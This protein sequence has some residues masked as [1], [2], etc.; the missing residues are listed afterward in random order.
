MIKKKH[1]MRHIVYILAAMPLL[2]G[3][4]GDFLEE[5]SQSEVIP[6]TT[7]DYS[8]LLIGNGYPDQYYPSFSF[9]AMMDD[10]C[11]GQVNA[12]A[13]VY[14]N[15]R[16]YLGIQNIFAEESQAVTPMPYYTWQPYEEDLD[17]YGS[18]INTVAST[19][20]YGQYYKKIMGCNAVLDGI[21]DAIGTQE[22]R[23][24]VKAEAL[25]VRALL[26]FQLV[27][28]FGEPYNYNPDAPGV[29][30]KLNANLSKD[31]I[32]RSSV[33]E[34]YNQIVADLTEAVALMDPLEIHTSNYRINQPALH[35]LLSR[36][37][38]FMERYQDCIDECD[39]AL[40]MG[41]R[42]AN[43]TVELNSTYSSS[44]SNPFT[45][46]NPE[47]LWNFGPSTKCGYS[48]CYKDGACTA[49]LNLWAQYV[50]SGMT[51][52]D[53]D[54]D[55][56]WD[57]YNLQAYSSTSK[58]IYVSTGYLCQSIRTAEAY[59]NKMEAEALLGQDADAL[60]DLNT[61]CAT[62]YANYTQRSLSGDGLLDN[63]R[64][65]RRKEFCFQGFR[66]FDLRRQGM[67]EITHVYRL[68]KAG[69]NVYYTLRHNDPL[70]TVPLPSSAFE[71]NNQLQQSE[72]RYEAERQYVEATNE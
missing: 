13:A 65:E 54:Y 26:Y 42:L 48:T 57:Q 3:S 29:P 32:P 53:A 36:V 31:G 49:F 16:T 55:M 72:C 4:C 67:P 10:D 6:K 2:L 50:N 14:D 12:E 68:Q 15:N 47:V 19:T 25:G 8:E 40:D 58:L 71:H 66:W 46:S 56:R 63:I 28:I 39:K 64:L 22:M 18:E 21:D 60:K 24:R 41:I 70:Y 69:P 38:L 20:A 23:N 35:I 43:L 7:E 52:G 45:Y 5:E 30:L 51:T 33:R 37:Y 62:R 34:V 27:N 61:F 9:T 11:E 59:M 44:S 17:G 1:D